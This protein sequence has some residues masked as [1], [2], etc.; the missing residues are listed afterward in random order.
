MTRT[1]P[2]VAFLILAATIHF[3]AEPDFRWNA[4][5]LTLT[6]PTPSEDSSGSV[7]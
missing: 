5:D 1:F 7:L 4:D 6:F 3:A 2:A